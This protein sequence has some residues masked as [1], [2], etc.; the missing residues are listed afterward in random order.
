MV[1]SRN[2]TLRTIALHWCDEL[3][4]MPFPFVSR[5]L[6]VMD[7]ID[8]YCVLR[9]EPREE[10]NEESVMTVPDE[11]LST[12]SPEVGAANGSAD[13]SVEDSE[14]IFTELIRSL[15]QQIRSQQKTEVIHWFRPS[16][17]RPTRCYGGIISLQSQK[18]E[19]HWRPQ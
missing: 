12:N 19:N 8:G 16:P 11:L 13:K 18:E 6:T 15:E 3:Q 4:L 2:N 1:R 10:H 7:V 5:E 14:E 9:P 17:V